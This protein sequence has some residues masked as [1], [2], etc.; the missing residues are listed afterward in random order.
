MLFYYIPQKNHH[1]KIFTFF[2]EDPFR[3]TLNYKAAYKVVL[4]WVSDCEVL[5]ETSLV[6]KNSIF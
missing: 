3:A 2:F 1:I 6:L 5:K 4:V